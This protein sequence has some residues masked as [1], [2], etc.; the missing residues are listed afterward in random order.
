MRER[1]E[2]FYRD[3]YDLYV[4]RNSRRAGGIENAEDVVQEAFCRALKY[5]DSFEVREDKHMETWFNTIVR[6]SLY[7][8]KRI[9]LKQGMTAATDSGESEAVEISGVDQMMA[10]EIVGFIE[11]KKNIDHKNV[12]Y[13]SLLRNYPPR[14][15]VEVLDLNL[16]NVKRIVVRFKQEMAEHYGYNRE[17][18]SF[19]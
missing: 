1:I 5:A 10:D 6:R 18:K 17:A 4:R 19:S 11:A 3:Y 15:I 14:D 16:E 8:F 7:D 2:Q 13:L 9:E 12:L